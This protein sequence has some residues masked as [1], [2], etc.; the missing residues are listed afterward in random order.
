MQIGKVTAVGPTTTGVKAALQLDTSPKILS[1]VHTTE[2][3][4]SAVGEHYV[5]LVPRWESGPYLHSHLACHYHLLES[6]PVDDWRQGRQLS[7]SFRDLFG[8]L[9]QAM[10]A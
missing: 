3:S 6:I 7:T 2:R 10:H 1:D 5:D 8:S 4:M 9:G